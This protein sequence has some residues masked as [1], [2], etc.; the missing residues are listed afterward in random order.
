MYEYVSDVLKAIK[1][2]PEDVLLIRHTDSTAKGDHRFEK[3]R[4]AGYVK[5][6]TAMQKEGFAK[7]RDYL[8]VF[9]GEGGTTARFFSL[10]SIGSRFTSRA[11]HAPADYPNPEELREPGEFLELREESLPKDLNGFTIEWGKA[12]QAWYQRAEIDK[13]IIEQQ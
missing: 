13:R 2:N 5:E 11:E 9:I 3:A 4:K 1:I 7:D 12:A 6:Y 8:M 10:Y